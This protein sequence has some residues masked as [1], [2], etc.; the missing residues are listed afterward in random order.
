MRSRVGSLPLANNRA[1]ASS[2]SGLSSLE[3]SESNAAQALS[4]SVDSTAAASGPSGSAAFAV[5]HAAT[6][7]QSPSM[8]LR[9]ERRGTS[10]TAD[11]PRAETLRA[12]VES[13]A[14]A[15]RAAARKRAS[16][17]SGPEMIARAL[18]C[19]CA[20]M[21]SVS[22][23]SAA[24]SAGARERAPLTAARRAAVARAERPR[25]PGELRP[26]RDLRC[27]DRAADQQRRLSRPER[28]VRRMDVGRGEGE[29][30]DGDDDKPAH[31]P[32][33]S[34]PQQPKRDAQ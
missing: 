10:A 4:L 22:F 20:A 8:R 18:I 13:R 11:A 1:S 27:A 3:A 9:R 33:G 32:A 5:I 14:P 16:S 12:S 31:P 21:A 24:S 2:S 30:S 17:A 15:K 19:S 34:R 26:S 6:V 29:P 28:R 7:Y 23:S 25:V